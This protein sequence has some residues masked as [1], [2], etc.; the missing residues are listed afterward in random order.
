MYWNVVCK[1]RYM[2]LIKAL[3]QQIYLHLGLWLKIVVF[4]V[5][6]DKKISIEW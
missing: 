4:I 2:V 1:L 5:K 3:F 6:Y